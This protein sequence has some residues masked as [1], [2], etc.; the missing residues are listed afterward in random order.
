MHIICHTVLIKIAIYCQK[1]VLTA[2][3]IKLNK[4]IAFKQFVFLVFKKKQLNIFLQLFLPT[5]TC[6]RVE[7]Y[8]Q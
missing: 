7:T 8:L 5:A 3:V 2:L 1:I 4:F 6:C